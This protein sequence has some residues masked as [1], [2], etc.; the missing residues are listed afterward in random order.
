L[1]RSSDEST[2]FYERLRQQLALSPAVEAV[3][4][5]SH[6]VLNDTLDSTG[7]AQSVDMWLPS[8]LRTSWVTAMQFRGD[9]TGATGDHLAAGRLLRDGDNADRDAHVLVNQAFADKYFSGT[10]LGRS[11]DISSMP[12]R[13]RTVTVV[14]VLA[15]SR[16]DR[17]NG[18]QV[19]WDALPMIYHQQPLANEA[20]RIVYL[21]VREG[22]RDAG[23]IFRDALQHVDS[24]VPL[25]DLRSAEDRRADRF[26]L[27]IAVSRVAGA[28]GGLATLL[29]ATGLFGVIAF[30]VATR[31]HEIGVRAVLGATPRDAIMLM[32]ARGLVPVAIGAGLGA[33][34]AV[35][36]SNVLRS[37]FSDVGAFQ[38]VALAQSVVLL[39]VIM[40]VAS[41]I[42]AM[43]AAR[44]DP[45]AVLRKE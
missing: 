17:T 21:R 3:A 20:A 38:P 28:I 2:A 19:R 42:P 33:V 35:G 32:L 36:L 7:P 26:R 9:V 18:R 39:L 31:S 16:L 12:G 45:I 4:V 30:L 6:D 15:G 40:V 25:L 41:V 5:I 10:A 14:G 11:F 23:P 44:V 24:R 29:A 8:S 34:A 43:R 1:R 22:T 27:E 13:R 37:R